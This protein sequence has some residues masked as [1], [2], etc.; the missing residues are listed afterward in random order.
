[1]T[2]ENFLFGT[3][4]TS[5]FIF[6]LLEQN[7]HCF[8]RHSHRDKKFES[9]LEGTSVRSMVQARHTPDNISATIWKI[10]PY[11][12]SLADRQINNEEN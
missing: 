3:D 6:K 10:E 12:Q 9:Y 5:Y 4:V 2:S 7:G 8:Q 1:M 11:S